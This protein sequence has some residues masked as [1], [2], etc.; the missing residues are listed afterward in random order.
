MVP[1]DRGQLSF[2]IGGFLIMKAMQVRILLL[3]EE[4]GVYP[5]KDVYDQGLVEEK[6]YS[7]LKISHFRTS[8]VHLGH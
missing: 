1:V 4:N 8:Y 3:R 2:R 5:K 7:I 6:H